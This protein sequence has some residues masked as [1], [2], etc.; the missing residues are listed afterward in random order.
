MRKKE[1]DEIRDLTMGKTTNV[2]I[3]H[4]FKFELYHNSM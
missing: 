4:F 3:S 2:L 1:R